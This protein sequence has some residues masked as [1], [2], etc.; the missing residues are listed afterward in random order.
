MAVYRDAC[1]R[2][3]PAPDST[4]RLK[5][6][7]DET[8]AEWKARRL[9]DT[10]LTDEQRATVIGCGY[11]DVQG[12]AGRTYRILTGGHVTGNVKRLSETEPHHYTRSYC[13]HVY[14]RARPVWDTF[15]AQ[16]FKLETDEPGF[17]N[18]AE[19]YGYHN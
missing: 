18:V 15:L 11:F 6:C 7:H 19:P 1:G 16:A 9:A 3:A 14:S 13:A 17:L 12:S 2:F 5:R 10:F 4:G 8:I